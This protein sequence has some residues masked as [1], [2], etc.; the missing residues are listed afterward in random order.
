MKGTLKKFTQLKFTS[1]FTAVL[2]I[3]MP[4]VTNAQSVA[5]GVTFGQPQSNNGPCVGKG[6]CR[7]AFDFSVSTN[8]YTSAPEAVT[9]T[10]QVSPD[11]ANIL[12][13]SFSLSELQAKQ[14]DKV[15]DFNDGGSYSFDAAYI[16]PT[17]IFGSL[18]LSP[19]AQILPT[20]S[21]TVKINGDFVTDYIT[22]SHDPK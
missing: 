21:S 20:S 19:N 7:E 9:V 17:S 15:A 16:L 12:M 4:C 10:F 6:Y 3:A 13:M 8:T 14:P 18:N 2:F 22:Y 11:N 1:F 5:F